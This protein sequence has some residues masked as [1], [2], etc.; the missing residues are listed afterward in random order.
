MADGLNQLNDNVPALEEGV[1][2][3]NAGAAKL[4]DGA[5]QVADGNE[6]LAEGANELQKNVP[7]LVDGVNQLNAGAKLVADGLLSLDSNL[8]NLPAAVKATAD[9]QKLVGAVGLIQGQIGSP[10]DTGTDTAL[11]ALNTIGGLMSG[12]TTAGST[13]ATSLGTLAATNTCATA[14]PTAD[15]P[16]IIKALDALTDLTAPT[17]PKP[18]DVLYATGA[19]SQ[20]AAGLSK[21]L[22]NTDTSGCAKT[23]PVDCGAYQA[24]EGIKQGIGTLVDSIA[25]GIYDS[26]NF[27]ALVAGGQTVSAGM[28]SLASKTPA[29]AGGVSQLATGADQLADGSAQ[30]ADGTETLAAGT[31]KLDAK[32]PALASGVSQLDDGAD[33]VAAGAD[34]LAAG[35]GAAADGSGQLADGLARPSRVVPRSRMAPVSSRSRAADE[36]AKTGKE[37]QLGYAKNVALLEAAQQAGLEG[38]GIPFG[39]AEGTDVVTTAAYKMY[40]SGIAAD[41]ENNALKYGLGVLLIAGAGGVAFM[42]ARKFAA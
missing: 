32:V 15:C 30:V 25:K 24:L 23:P 4:N 34:K 7:A 39:N 22:Y 19:T 12:A 3:L 9:Y 21:K 28:A 20:I 13:A 42:A 40:L 17:A 37:A 26:A 31:E 33:Q 27:K 29:L 2:D 36:L 5:Q 38:A 11:G 14:T 10:T 16:D 18:G 35:L 41:T 6:K 8:K 1:S